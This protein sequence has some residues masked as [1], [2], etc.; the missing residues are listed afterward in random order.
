MPEPDPPPR[1]DDLD[2]RF[3]AIV[4]RLRDPDGTPGESGHPLPAESTSPDA[5]SPETSVG[6]GH[7]AINP[8]PVL[9][10]RPTPAPPPLQVPVWRGAT[11][12]APLQDLVAGD[13]EEHYVP[14]PPR[15]YPP[16]EH[17]QVRGVIIGLVAG[18][19]LLLWLLLVRPD[20]AQWWLWVAISMIAGGFILLVL[21]G[22][23]DDDHGNGA[24]V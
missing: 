24:V 2:A 23:D 21:R 20:V 14:P 9:R 18:T 17:L 10:I 16:Q 13:G 22:G 12:D 15:P 5:N 8:P 6:P 19:V 11:S 3:E 4:A 1:E 7:P